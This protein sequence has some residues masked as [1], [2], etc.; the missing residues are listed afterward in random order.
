MAARVAFVSLGAW[1]VVISIGVA[2]FVGTH[3]TFEFAAPRAAANVAA[4]ASVTNLAALAT[5]PTL[6]ASSFE[7]GVY[8]LAHPAYLVD[9]RAQPTDR[10][11]WTPRFDDPAPWLEIV[12]REP[13]DIE[14]VVLRHGSDVEPR[15][16]PNRAYRLRCL[17][18]EAPPPLQ[19]T[20]NRNAV[21]SHALP[22][23]RASGVRIDFTL[24]RKRPLAVYEVEVFGR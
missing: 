19:V 8:D 5:G 1:A 7:R 11:K 15:L 14:R 23:R 17:G 6:R 18:H 24:A 3:A 13:H 20:D 12:F 2:R 4:P 10:E 21:A 22:C 9:G 16:R